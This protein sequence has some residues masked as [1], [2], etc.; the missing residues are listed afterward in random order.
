MQ[1]SIPTAMT[2]ASNIQFVNGSFNGHDHLVDAF[3]SALP[4]S[5]KEKETNDKTIETL[6]GDVK[7]ILFS[8]GPRTPGPE[9]NW[10]L[11]VC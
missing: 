4:P 5:I 1:T 8:S 7:R 6:Y 10:A 2:I 3:L 11:A 9:N